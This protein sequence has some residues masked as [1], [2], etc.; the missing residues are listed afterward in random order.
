[1]GF[2]DS[3]VYHIRPVGT[4][5]GFDVY[6]DMNIDD[7]GWTVFQRREDGTVNFHRVWDEYQFGFG[8]V[9]GEHWL[10]NIALHA[11]TTQGHYE[12]RVDLGDWAGNTSFAKYGVFRVMHAKELYKMIIGG[13]V[14]NT[15]DSLQY[16]NNMH[17]TT[18][19]QDNDIHTTSN[20]AESCKGG[21]WYGSCHRAN[22]NGLYL[23]EPIQGQAEE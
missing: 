10:G 7:G 17:F 12:L 21:W 19:D 15:G 14:G 5:R 18:K 8:N 9:T 16:H 3:G 4:Y 23:T 6:C 11:I 20:C 2:N 22:L 1:M 13:Y